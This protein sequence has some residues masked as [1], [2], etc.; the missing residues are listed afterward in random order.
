M[1]LLNTYNSDESSSEGSESQSEENRMGTNDVRSVY[2]ITYSQAD[3]QKFSTRQ[4]FASAVVE[5][6]SQGKAKVVHWCCCLEN[7]KKSGQHYHLSLKLDRNQRWLPSKA[8][9]RDVY[10]IT[11]HYS[12]IHHNYYSAWKYV[13][14]SDNEFQESQGHPRLC[15][16]GEPQTST[17]SRSR[18]QRRRRQ[19]D[20]RVSEEGEEDEDTE[21]DSESTSRQHKKKKKRLSAF[22]VSEIIIEHNIRTITELQALA[23]EQKHEGKTDIAE[24]LLNRNPRA[25]ADVLQSAWEIERAPEK[26]ARSKISRM[27]LLEEAREGTCIEGC[28]RNWLLCAH[29]IFRNN[30]VDVGYFANSVKELLSKGRG[31]YRNMML[32]GPA[33]C[34]KTFLLNPLTTI[35]NTFCNPATGSFAW[36]GLEK[37]E[38]IFLNDFRWSPQLIPW[39][40]LLL[41]LEGQEVHLP[42]P[43]THFAKDIAFS[44][45]TPIFCTSKN[46][47]VHIKNGVL[48]ERETDMMR[49]R[50]NLI[51]FNFQIPRDAQRD[52]PSCPKC[53]S[54]LIMGEPL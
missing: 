26:L 42:A 23:Y 44:A 1:D 14:K 45:D 38:C 53:F 20:V 8:Y 31:K 40:D 35:Y 33:N 47:L 50:W 13:T 29:E 48:D 5:S 21:T 12:S 36:I 25:V 54:D 15:A 34:G 6:F 24:F 37:A 7:H 16:V 17:A 32:T 4:A 9:L 51:Q 43:K 41:L 52:V 46:P 28:N 3:T 19:S 49:V 27:E 11:V 22:E 18:T 39:H 10:G 30:G 2:L